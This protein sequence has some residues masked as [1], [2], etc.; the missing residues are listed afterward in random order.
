MPFSFETFIQNSCFVDFEEF[1]AEGDDR[2]ILIEKAKNATEFFLLEYT[3][4][5]L[6][7]MIF[8]KEK[9][10]F[11]AELKNENYL[12]NKEKILGKNKFP[13]IL[14]YDINI[15]DSVLFPSNYLDNDE[16]NKRDKN[17]EFIRVS[18]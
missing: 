15:N 13:N 3:D 10:S 9:L 16:K 11:D 5:S 14:K 7:D 4:Y 2:K 18:T 17:Y 12:T 1:I 6:N 8:S